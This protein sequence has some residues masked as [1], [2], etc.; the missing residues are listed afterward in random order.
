MEADPTTPEQV[1]TCLARSGY[2]L[3]SQLVTSLVEE[4]YFVEPNQVIKDPR[5][6]KSREIDLVAEHYSKRIGPSDRVCVKTH[7]VAE[8]INNRYPVVLMTER[9]MSPNEDFENWVKYA[10][11]PIDN[12]FE[13][14]FNIYDD[15]TPP[16]A[17]L[18]SQYCGLTK[19][20]RNDELM[21]SHP[22]DMYSSLLK[23]AEFTESERNSFV[24][25]AS[26]L[27]DSTWRIF[28]WHPM[29]VLGGQLMMT[30][31]D[32]SGNPIVVEIETAALEFNWH[33]GE[34]RRSTLIEFITAAAF[35]S[36]LDQIILADAEWETRLAAMRR[37]A[38]AA[39]PMEYK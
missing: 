11:T 30:T 20:N 1:L 38:F 29:L 4:G 31:K 26:E 37:E 34:T 2:L 25:M 39:D 16:R 21:A 15:R 35:Q 18:F 23:L 28:F 33:E 5:T 22:D 19:K 3:E 14:S 6:G 27:S 24:S 32:E 9:P 36:R 12:S 7:F 17:Y 8:I 10:V 13:T